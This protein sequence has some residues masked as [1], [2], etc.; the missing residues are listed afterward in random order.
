MASLCATSCLLLPA[1]LKNSA[2]ALQQSWPI[3]ITRKTRWNSLKNEKKKQKTN[4]P[5]KQ[6][7]S[8]HACIFQ[9]VLWKTPFF[10]FFSVFQ[11]FRISC[12]YDFVFL[13]SLQA[14][15]GSWKLWVV[16][17]G[18][19]WFSRILVFCWSQQAMITEQRSQDHFSWCYAGLQPNQKYFL[20]KIWQKLHLKLWKES[21]TQHFIKEPLADKRVLRHGNEVE[22]RLIYTQQHSE[23]RIVP[24]WQGN[25]RDQ[26][27]LEQEHGNFPHG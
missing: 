12:N 11:Y 22:C 20:G 24:T 10:Q 26:A 23:H 18:L 25:T 19:P 27:T 7:L 4:K 21:G 8:L 5:R 3:R 13:S 6:G 1:S 17:C 15:S 14:A 2:F 16:S 9:I